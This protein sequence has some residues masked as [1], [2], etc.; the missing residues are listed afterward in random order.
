[1]LF[2]SAASGVK[3]LNVAAEVLVGTMK[4]FGIEGE[5]A[6]AVPDLL[7]NA[8]NVSALKLTD[9]QQAIAAGG[10]AA[11]TSGVDLTAFTA[12]MS[13]MRDRLIGASDAGTSFKAFTQALTPNSKDAAAAMAKLGFHAFDA[14]GKMKPLRQIIAELERGMAGYTDEQRLATLELIFGSDGVRT[15]T[16]LLDAYNT[17]NG[18]GV[19]LLDERADALRRQGTADLAAKERTSS[20]TAAQAEL[21]SKIQTLKQRIGEAL[22]PALESLIGIFGRFIDKGLTPAVEGLEKFLNLVNGTKTPQ[23][24]RATL[25]ITAS[26]DFTTGVLKLLGGGVVGIQQMLDGMNASGQAQWDGWMGA[27]SESQ[28]RGKAAALRRDLINNNLLKPLDGPDGA[29]RQVTMILADYDRY[30]KIWQDSVAK[31]AGAIKDSLV[32]DGVIKAGQTYAA[33]TGPATLAGQGPL[34]PGQT[35]ATPAALQV[36]SLDDKSKAFFRAIFGQESGG[37]YNAF[38]TDYRKGGGQGALGKYQVMPQNILGMGWDVPQAQRGAWARANLDNM[39]VLGKGWDFEVLKKD[40]TPR[41]FLASKEYQEAISQARMSANLQK[42]L[43]D[44]GGN[45]EMA[46]KEAAKDWYGR[47]AP[48]KGPTPDQYAASIWARFQQEAG[49]GGTM[50]GT[51]PVKKGPASSDALKAEA[52]RLLKAEEAAKKAGNVDRVVQVQ[53]MLKAFTDSGPRAA[54]ALDLVRDKLGQAKKEV[55]Q[56]GQGYDR[57]NQ[58][59]DTAENTFKLTD[60]TKGYIKVLGAVRDGAL[61]AAEAERRA[62]GETEKYQALKKLAGDAASKA[63]Q[64]QEGQIGR[65]HV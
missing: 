3:D 28:Q 51:T 18:Q 5:A 46:V 31:G 21:A 23:E 24:I 10:S 27:L 37:D 64:Q 63:R 14:T 65:A 7:A 49:S 6:A 60:D 1:M 45:L 48:A 34:L 62:N 41:Q 53:G 58:S 56:F 20:L 12:T 9:F 43:M 2:R 35:R 36:L 40:I 52:E 11:R 38:N 55:S 13:L 33:L 22:A 50:P 25:K 16:T 61:K 42:R 15:A 30:L 57:L 8:A 54:A 17:K 19:R 32:M 29:Y 39:G 44:A 59:L 26:D 4:A 47:V